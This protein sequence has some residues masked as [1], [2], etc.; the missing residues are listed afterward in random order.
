MCGIVGVREYH[1]PNLPSPASVAG[2]ALKALTNRGQDTTGIAI[3]DHGEAFTLIGGP[4]T[5]E[6]VYDFEQLASFAGRVAIGENRYT[7]DGDPGWVQPTYENDGTLSIVHNGNLSHPDRLIEDMQRLGIDTSRANDTQLAS[8]RLAWD[9]K[10]GVPLEEAMANLFSLIADA[11]SFCII[12]ADQNGTMAAMRDPKA[13]QPLVVAEKNGGY[14]VASETN[15]LD[16]VGIKCELDNEMS[17]WRDVEPGELLVFDDSGMRSIQLAEG[18][19]ATCSLNFI[20]VAHDNSILYH[21]RVRK[22]RHNIGRQ[23]AIEHPPIGGLVMPVPNTANPYAEGYVE[24]ALKDGLPVELVH[25]LD[26][27]NEAKGLR[28]FMQPT[29]EMRLDGARKKF[30]VRN[31]AILPE[32]LTVI[33]DSIIRGNVQ[34]V[35]NKLLRRLG[36]KQIH[37]R[38]GSPPARWPNRQGVA[39]SE[40]EELVAYDRDVDGVRRYIDADSLGHVSLAGLVAGIN[41]PEGYTISTPDF[42][43]ESAITGAYTRQPKRLV[44]V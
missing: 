43:G 36:V 2:E 6:K 20:Y 38:I 15:A 29:P 39:T 10:R 5:A 25:L 4:G 35:L 41:P 24:Q 40:Q 34:S 37:V 17:V 18:H 9:V 32:E 30:Q 12:A 1:N 16:A 31:G 8:R 33:D 13:T 7:T 27:P 21:Q 11:G 23:L 3:N 28:T 22:I 44:E 42:T 19:Y 14:V 26:I